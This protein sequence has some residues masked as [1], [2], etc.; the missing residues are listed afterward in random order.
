V[1]DSDQDLPLL[2]NRVNV[3]LNKLANWF[4]ANKMAVNISKTKY[5]IFSPRG[6]NID[7]TNCE[8]VFNNNEIGQPYD[9]SKV[10]TL[11]RIHNNN[12]VKANRSY[13]LIGLYLDEFMSF[14][15]HV[16]HI[17]NKIAQSNLLSFKGS[18]FTRRLYN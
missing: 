15:D 6:V 1:L 3:E 5:I 8:I 9:P 18:I 4:R 2:I 10:T 12:P 14:D 13:K 16:T 11:E 17:C 7:L